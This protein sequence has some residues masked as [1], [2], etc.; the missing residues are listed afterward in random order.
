MFLRVC[1]IFI[2]FFLSKRS[3]TCANVRAPARLVI[4]ILGTEIYMFEGMKYEN[5]RIYASIMSS[6]SLW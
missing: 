4:I 1:F 2:S 5:V 3:L 6:L